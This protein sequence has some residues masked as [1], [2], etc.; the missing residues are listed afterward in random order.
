[1]NSV[2][3]WLQ[4][5]NTW[6]PVDGV[7]FQVSATLPE[8]AHHWGWALTVHY[9]T[10]HS[11]FSLCLVFQVEDMI[12]QLPV[13]ATFGQLPQLSLWTL[14]L[15]SWAK[16]DCS[17]HCLGHNVLSQQQKVVNTYADRDDSATLLG[18]LW[19]LL[20][21]SFVRCSKKMTLPSSHGVWGWRFADHTLVICWD[22]VL[23]I[24]PWP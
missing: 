5:L 1:M 24:S 16:I 10:P 13:I 21:A 20:P 9:F 11:V 7:V 23:G 22:L 12:S 6:F 2:S 15:E 3:H 17:I 19:I 18:T 4:Y 8:E 14:P